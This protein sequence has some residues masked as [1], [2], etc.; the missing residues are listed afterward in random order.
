MSTTLMLAPTDFQTFLRPW[1]SRQDRHVI[2]L[3]GRR[4]LSCKI[5]SCLLWRPN[6]MPETYPDDPNLISLQQ[7]LLAVYLVY[8]RYAG[9]MG[10]PKSQFHPLH[11][12]K[13][14][15]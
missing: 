13:H 1:Y 5:Q 2:F 14:S 10:F 7:F 6:V 12:Y 11:I 15:F 3:A 8:H 4:V 9:S